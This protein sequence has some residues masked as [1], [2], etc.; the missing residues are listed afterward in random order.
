MDPELLR[1][2]LKRLHDELREVRQVD[3]RSSELLAEVLKDIQRLLPGEAGSA[4]QPAHAA[5][6]ATPTAAADAA[7]ASLPS[8]LERLAV[9]FEVDHPTLAESLRRLIDLLGKAGL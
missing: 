6:R 3:L 9:Q 4:A 1:E 2:H 8:R 5:P 7:T